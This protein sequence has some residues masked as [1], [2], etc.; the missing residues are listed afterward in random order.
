VYARPPTYRVDDVSWDGI[1][2]VRQIVEI[3]A[4]SAEIDTQVL[5]ASLRHPL[6]VVQAAM[7]GA[8]VGTAPYSVLKASVKHPLTDIGNA[9]FLKDWEKVPD[10]DI[11][12]QVER[13]LAK[14]PP[15]KAHRTA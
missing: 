8:D 6:H 5:A 12:G 9:R 3:Y 11:S 4:Q 14:R 10:R 15:T 13:W 7:A 2:L 1:E